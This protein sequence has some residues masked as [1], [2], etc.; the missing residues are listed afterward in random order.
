MHG[1]LLIGLTGFLHEEVIKMK[2][3]LLVIDVQRAIFTKKMAV[4]HAAALIDNVNHLMVKARQAGALI[5]LVQHAGVGFSPG[6]EGWQ[7]HPDLTVCGDEINIQKLKGNAFDGTPLKAELMRNAVKRVVICGC[8]THG[9]V[10]A[11]TLGALAEGYETVL[12]ADAHSNY[13][14][15][16]EQLVHDW[17]DKLAK[18]GALVLPTENITI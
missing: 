2:T 11:S 14:E 18:A 5:V 4:Y 13:S 16:A 1:S 12:A 3:A 8:V 10:K 6:S 17:N 15:K 9:C 7:I